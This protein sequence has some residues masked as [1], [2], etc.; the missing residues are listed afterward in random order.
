MHLVRP[1]FDQM[2]WAHMTQ[3]SLPSPMYR[4]AF[5][6]GV[7]SCSTLN[8]LGIFLAFAGVTEEPLCTHD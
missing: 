2:S 4:V 6:V 1:W 8:E 5:E 7:I 3:I